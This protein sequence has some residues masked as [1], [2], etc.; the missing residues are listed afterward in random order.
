[1]AWFKRVKEGIKP[2]KKKDLPNLWVKCQGC[3]KI[4]YKSV[5]EKNFHVCPECEFHFR[6]SSSDYVDLLLDNGHFE[7]FNTNVAPVDFLKF[8]AIKKYSDQLKDGHKKTGRHDAVRTGFG[9]VHGHKVVF[10]IMDFV[11]IGGSMGSVVGEKIA[12]GIDEALKRKLHL[13]I[14]SASGGARMQEGV[15]SLMQMAKISA[16]LARLSDRGLLHIALLT[17]PTSGGVTASY[18]MLGDVILAEPG[19]FIGFA[20]P[21]V[22]KQTIGQDLPDGFQNSEFQ[23]KHGFVD[24]V[25]NRHELK[26]K[27]KLI[28]GF[29]TDYEV[30]LEST[31]GSLE[32]GHLHQVVDEVVAIKSVEDEAAKN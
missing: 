17:N 9:S 1:M 29:A 13:I 8:K 19:A 10:C 3:E 21:R 22:I 18:A 12:R 32:P 6:I 20:G 24:A 4:I 16:R 25:V 27:L 11:F 26:D 30:E 7:E 5:L 28:L 23:L 15:I 14:L 2:Q 31:N